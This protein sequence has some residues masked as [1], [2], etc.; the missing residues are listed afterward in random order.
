MRA[1]ENKISFPLFCV[2]LANS[3]KKSKTWTAAW[4]FFII[5]LPFLAF[6]SLRRRNGAQRQETSKAYKKRLVK[7]RVRGF[8]AK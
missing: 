7:K 6:S 3:V 1:E 4:K 5:T 8:S 2:E